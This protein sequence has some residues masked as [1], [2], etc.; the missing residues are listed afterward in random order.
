MT[1]H[2]IH[3]TSTHPAP[4]WQKAISRVAADGLTLATRLMLTPHVTWQAAPP[5]V[6]QP[7]IYYANHTSHS[8]TLLVRA[9]LPGPLRPSLSPVAAQDFWGKT[10]FR[11]SLAEQGLNATLIARSGRAMVDG[12]AHMKNRLTVGH[13]LLIYPEGT[14]GDTEDPTRFRC[15]LH[16]L[17]KSCPDIP[18]V[19]VRI[20][21]AVRVLPKGFRLPIPL[22][23]RVTF[24]PPLRPLSDDENCNDFL[25][26]ARD[27]LN[28]KI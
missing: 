12:F 15:G 19:P 21:R 18:L 6:G 4:R 7:V 11:Q 24:C 10:A 20:D 17:A 8:D 9:A 13:S 1:S 25:S 3:T 27:A 23:C 2:A 14:R 16:R 22:P 26:R 5:A 28:R